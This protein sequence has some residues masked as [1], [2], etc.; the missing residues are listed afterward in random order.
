[1]KYIKENDVEIYCTI[2]NE[3]FDGDDKYMNEIYNI[4]NTKIKYRGKEF[5]VP[6]KTFK[7]IRNKNNK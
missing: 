7:I 4:R 5:T 2:I 1:M 3:D 6:K